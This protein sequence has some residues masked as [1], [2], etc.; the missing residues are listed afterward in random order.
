MAYLH[1]ILAYPSKPRLKGALNRIYGYLAR[2]RAWTE[3]TASNCGVSRLRERIRSV[4]RCWSFLR[5][6]DLLPDGH[7][8]L[9]NTKGNPPKRIPLVTPGSDESGSS[10]PGRVLS[11][12]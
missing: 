8:Q 7:S 6:V 12:S 11:T 3:K 5:H 1:T 2:Y 10:I 4:R 9:V